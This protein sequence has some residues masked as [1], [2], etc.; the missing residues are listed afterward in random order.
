MVVTT[1]IYVLVAVSAV[2]AMGS[3]AL[4]ESA[5]PLA[6]VAHRALG[7]RADAA[8]SAIALAATANT[9]RLLLA[10]ASRSVYGMAAAGVLPRALAAVGPTAIP[11]RATVGV[12]TLAGAVVM[13]GDLTQI[14]ALTDAAVLLSFILVNLSLPWL[15][16]RGATAGG[17]RRRTA[18]L[19][20]PSAGVLLCGFLLLHTGWRSLLVAGAVGALGMLVAA[21]SRRAARL[22]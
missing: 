9:V 14:A 12:L 2:A 6:V 8:M 5:A 4:S 15:A 17:R 20:L 11:V 10:S 7:P 3:R 13:A 22:Q 21:R 18:D 19:V 16:A 1:V